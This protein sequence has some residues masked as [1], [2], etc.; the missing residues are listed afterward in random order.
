[1][2][3]K[4][5]EEQTEVVVPDGYDIFDLLDTDDYVRLYNNDC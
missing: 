5:T 3:Q 2:K 4:E 1:M